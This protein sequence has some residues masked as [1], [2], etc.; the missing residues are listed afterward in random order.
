MDKREQRVSSPAA[1]AQAALDE[2]QTFSLIGEDVLV[3][4]TLMSALNYIASGGKRSKRWAGLRKGI[5]HATATNPV[6]TY[7]RSED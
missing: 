1:V 5:E 7:D 2:A 4:L 3:S 6:G